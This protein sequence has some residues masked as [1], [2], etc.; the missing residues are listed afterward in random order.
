MRPEEDFFFNYWWLSILIFSSIGVPSLSPDIRYLMALTFGLVKVIVHKE[1]A[2]S[3][4]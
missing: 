4:H 1:S 2:S 3:G